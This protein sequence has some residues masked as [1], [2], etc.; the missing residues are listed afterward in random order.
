M[1]GF[2][3]KRQMAVDK[4]AEMLELCDY[5]EGNDASLE[6][7]CKAAA[8]IRETLAQPAQEPVALSMKI[9]DTDVG[10]SWKTQE[11]F[12]YFRVEPFGPFGWTDCAETDEGAVALYETPPQRPWVGL[13][14]EE[15]FE[16]GEKLGLA[17]VAWLDLMQAI[18][19]ALRSKNT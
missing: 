3:S 4:V 18:E 16:I 15:R 2:D 9:T 6:A 8:F 12:G 7:Q 17:D 5:L 14:D 10:L 11:P 13:T 1:T 19:A